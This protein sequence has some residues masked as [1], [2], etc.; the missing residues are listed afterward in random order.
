MN[1]LVERNLSRITRALGLTG[2]ENFVDGRGLTAWAAAGSK[3]RRAPSLGLGIT[4]REEKEDHHRLEYGIPAMVLRRLAG[5]MHEESESHGDH[6]DP[7]H[8]PLQC[9]LPPSV[10]HAFLP[11]SL[12]LTSHFSILDDR[13]T[14]P[15]DACHCAETACVTLAN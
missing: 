14:A 2:S 9:D 1:L 5:H 15:L 10:L 11:R 13:F 4:D 3:R 12:D 6:R 8:H 7:N